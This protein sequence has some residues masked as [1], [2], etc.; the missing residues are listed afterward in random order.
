MGSWAKEI[1]R[2]VQA[3]EERVQVA[4]DTYPLYAGLLADVNM[5]M[6]EQARSAM[7]RSSDLI[8]EALIV[9]GRT[10]EEAEGLA[11][12]L[13]GPLIDEAMTHS[14]TIGPKHAAS[15]GL[16]VREADIDG[17]MWQLIW[18]LWTRY[19]ALGAWPTA[20]E[21]CTRVTPHHRSH[22]R[23]GSRHEPAATVDDAVQQLPASIGP[24][25]RPLVWTG[26]VR[27]RLGAGRVTAGVECARSP[28]IQSR[29]RDGNSQTPRP[30]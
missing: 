17:D 19:F 1:E 26:R 2:A 8:R 30:G 28:T 25:P 22:H 27:D 11:A 23:T 18:E 4:P 3:A 6:V 21:P 10:E 12:R 13:K 24:R 5:L 20:V 29:Y 14:A 9:S 7:A 16:P 15:L